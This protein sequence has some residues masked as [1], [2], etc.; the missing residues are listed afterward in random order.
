MRRR[1]LDFAAAHRGAAT[2]MAAAVLSD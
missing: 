1:A 2:R